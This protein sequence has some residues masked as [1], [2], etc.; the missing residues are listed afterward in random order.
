[1]IL[2]P[3][4]PDLVFPSRKLVLFVHG[5]FWHRCP[6]GRDGRKQIYSNQAYWTG[7]LATNQSRDKKHVGELELLGCEA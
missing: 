7:K 4:K 3:G 6:T 1:M 2:L 5:C